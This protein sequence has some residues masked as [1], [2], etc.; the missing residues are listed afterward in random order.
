MTADERELLRCI[1]EVEAWLTASGISGLRSP[2]LWPDELIGPRTDDS[3]PGDLLDRLL[4][5]ATLTRAAV[6]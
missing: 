5:D 2:D 6:E 3:P 1:A 4:G